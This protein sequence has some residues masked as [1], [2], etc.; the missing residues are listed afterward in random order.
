MVH[1]PRPKSSMPKKSTRSSLHPHGA[2]TFSETIEGLGKGLANLG[3]HLAGAAAGMAGNLIGDL[4]NLKK[5]AAEGDDEADKA[6]QEALEMLRGSESSIAA[7][8]L[9]ELGEASREGSSASDSERNKMES[10]EPGADNEE[11]LH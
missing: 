11:S 3:A 4:S 1:R 8:L 7:E 2:P 10:G 5:S 9:A 6:Y